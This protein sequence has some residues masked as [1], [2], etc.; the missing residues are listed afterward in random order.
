[1]GRNIPTAQEEIVEV[2]VSGLDDEDKVSLRKR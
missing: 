1:V 2:R